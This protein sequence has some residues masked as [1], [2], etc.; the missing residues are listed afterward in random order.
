MQERRAFFR[1]RTPGVEDQAPIADPKGELDDLTGHPIARGCVECRKHD[2]DCSMT[3]NGEFPCAQCV[4]DGTE[5]RPIVEFSGFGQGPCNLCEQRDIPCSFEIGGVSSICD[6][7]LDDDNLECAPGARSGYTADRIDL[8]RILYGPDRKYANC[9]YCRTH[10][11]RCSLKKKE[12]KPPCKYCKK[13]SIGCTFDDALPLDILKKSQGK[14]RK[15][16]ADATASGSSRRKAKNG[17][18]EVSIPD[19]EFFDAEDLMDLQREDDQEYER[20]DTPEMEMED[21]E[22]RKGFI[23]KIQTSFAHPI[24]FYTTEEDALTCSFCEFP[25]F[26]FVGYFEKT[27]HVIKWHNGMGYTEIAAGHREEHDA[28]TMCQECT[29]PRLQIM[30]CP[31]HT[32]QQADEKDA[33]QDFDAAADELMHAELSAEVVRYQLQRWCSMCFSLATFRCCV[34]QPSIT[35][36]MD[37][38]EAIDGCGL[39]LCDRCEHELRVVFEGDFRNMADAFD[40][41]PKA[42]AED[43]G[44]DQVVI[45]A[46]VG[47]LK[48]DGLL[49][50]TIELQTED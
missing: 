49:M 36:P 32:M 42:S 40:G 2:Q 48:A 33:A 5:C 19:S 22:G 8:N 12:D 31:R 27:I 21:A 41:R 15:K 24:K 34:P 6:Q 4:E 11:K 30:A 23:T 47:F 10:K 16:A 17:P 50:K 45:R 13:H 38:E 18:P 39:R 46:D 26:G 29:I 3:Q 9:T 14:G 28:T 1:R 35:A 37:D 44:E 20:E 43:D 7:C 25:V